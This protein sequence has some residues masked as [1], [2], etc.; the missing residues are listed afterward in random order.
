MTL[1]SS[2]GL[3][4]HIVENSRPSLHGNTL[5]DGEYSEQDVIELRDAIIGTDPGVI[6]V[7]LLWTFPHST[8]KC[9]LRRVDSLIVYKNKAK[10]L[11]N[12][13]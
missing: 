4:I 1:C 8:C 7:V 10:L 6:A 12:V 9:Q 3:N 2:C 5:E 11:C 13:T